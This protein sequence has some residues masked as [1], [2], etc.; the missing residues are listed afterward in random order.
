MINEENIVTVIKGEDRDIL[1]RIVDKATD[2]PFDLTNASAIN[3]R[4]KNEDGTILVKA[5][6]AGSVS[7]V[8]AP[9]GKVQVSLAAAETA[10]MKAR[11][12]QDFEIEIVI[13]S[14][15]TSKLTVVQFLQALTVKSRVV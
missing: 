7:V 1:L 14:G 4:F 13:G 12:A 11:E 2:Q 5:L 3:A 9:S 6:A 15:S 8:S 10:L